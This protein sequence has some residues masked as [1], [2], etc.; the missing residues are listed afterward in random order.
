MPL[1]Q[2]MRS[3]CW[4]YNLRR[5]PEAMG[6]P[7]KANE[8]GEGNDAVGDATSRDLGGQ[9]DMDSS[10]A[11]AR[12]DMEEMRK[13]LGPGLN[14]EEQDFFARELEALDAAAARAAGTNGHGE[15][16]G[17]SEDFAAHGSGLDAGMQMEG[18]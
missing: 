17:E 16:M 1:E 3:L 9:G 10:G 13:N 11:D 12:V 14:E 15:V 8:G 6:R 5:Y 7:T 18:W 4:W 2:A